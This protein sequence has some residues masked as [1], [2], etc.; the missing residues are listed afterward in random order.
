MFW[1]MVFWETEPEPVRTWTFK[2][3]KDRSPS[4]EFSCLMLECQP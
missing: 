4:S 1:W 3:S 2:E